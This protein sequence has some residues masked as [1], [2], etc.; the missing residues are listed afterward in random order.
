MSSLLHRITSPAVHS[1]RIDLRTYAVS[2]DTLI[3]E[4][5]LADLRHRA[6]FDLTGEEQ[7]AGPIHRM[8]IRLLLQVA[9]KEILDAEVEML[10]VPHAECRGLLASLDA[11]VGL[12]V[13]RGFAKQVSQRIGG[14]KGCTHLTHLL[15]VMSQ[16]VFQGIVVVQREK[17]PP[18]PKAL[19]DIPGLENLVGS[20]KMWDQ[21]GI[22]LR[23]I[24]K[25]IDKN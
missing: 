5:E 16:E 2:E 7:A 4:G 17:K 22:K 23:N 19:D 9:S 14:V 20:C 21:G 15:T 12:R 11:I 10:H 1:R 13:E 6:V 25:A 3:V 24:Q 18:V 8:V